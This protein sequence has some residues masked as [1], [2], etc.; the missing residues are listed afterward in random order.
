MCR[1][2]NILLLLINVVC[3][4]RSRNLQHD[5]ILRQV[6]LTCILWN[7]AV[8]SWVDLVSYLNWSFQAGCCCILWSTMNCELLAT[9]S[10]LGYLEGD[11]YHKES[12][13]LGQCMLGLVVNARLDKFFS[14]C[15]YWK[16]SLTCL[17]GHFSTCTAESIKDLIRYLRHE[18]DTRDVRQQLGAGQIIQNDLLPII[19][20]HGHD[21]T[22]FDACVRYDKF[23][24]DFLG[25]NF[26]LFCVISQ[27]LRVMAGWKYV[28]FLSL[29]FSTF[30]DQR[31][32]SNSDWWSTLLSLP[33]F[34]LVKSLMIQCL[35]I[36]F[37][38]WRL[39]CRPIR[40]Y[41]VI[42]VGR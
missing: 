22:L 5:V 17:S 9:C 16:Q 28:I 25:M 42:F 38:K 11:T 18:D 29:E 40:R 26:R 19:T 23:D 12:D 1:D 13:C 4:I 34:A 6:F 15:L 37:W 10:A 32:P 8:K 3:L 2:R 7:K 24:L 36:T 35:D 33:W 41:Q 20:Q 21:K 39:I 27:I 14:P 31:F 30:D